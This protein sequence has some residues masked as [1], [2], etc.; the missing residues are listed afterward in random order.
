MNTQTEHRVSVVITNRLFG[1][2]KIEIR[3]GN[4]DGGETSLELTPHECGELA[5]QL[6]NA[7]GSA[8]VFPESYPSPVESARKRSMA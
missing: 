3:F 7:S 6:Q 4:D 2:T 8:S 5:K 1:D